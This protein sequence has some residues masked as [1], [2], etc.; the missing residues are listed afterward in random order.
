MTQWE[1]QA[2]RDATLDKYLQ[3]DPQGHIVESGN[4]E[5]G[6]NV[7]F[8]NQKEYEDN[9]KSNDGKQDSPSYMDQV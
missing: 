9:S 5:G 6:I 7:L 8:K 3:Q 2:T 1:E 4:R